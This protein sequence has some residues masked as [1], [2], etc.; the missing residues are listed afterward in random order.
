M[1]EKDY[2][3]QIKLLKEENELLKN[4]ILEFDK[5]AK[6]LLSFLKISDTEKQPE[7]SRAEVLQSKFNDTIK[8]NEL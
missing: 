4:I 8:D 5:R 1:T 3:R 6:S 7:K 2:K